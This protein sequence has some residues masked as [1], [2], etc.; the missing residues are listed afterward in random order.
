MKPDEI[1]KWKK[2]REKG[3]A[4]FIAVTGILSFGLPMFVAQNFMF[5]PD[6]PLAFAD[7]LVLFLITTV[8]G[9]MLFGYSMWIIQER[10]Y[11]KANRAART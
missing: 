5:L 6:K 11:A 3:M 4:R 8:A 7:Y 9:G 1:E 2:T 10:R